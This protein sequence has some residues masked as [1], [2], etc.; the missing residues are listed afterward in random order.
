V[1]RLGDPPPIQR[2]RRKLLAEAHGEVLEIGVGSGVNFAHYDPANVSKL[3]ALEPNPEMVRLAESRRQRTRLDVEFLGLPGERIPLADSSVDTV[4]STFTLCT[5]AG[6]EE[7]IRG[8]KRVLK[9]GGRLIFFEIGASSDPRIRRWQRRWEP[10][11]RRL[12]EGLHLTRDIPGLLQQAG[13]SMATVE[14]GCMASFPKSWSHCCWGV[15]VA[16][17]QVP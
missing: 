4:V 5:I 16:R 14:T 6:V 8:V 1:Q 17:T 15:A 13:F 12:F 10:L 2:L 9:P 3:Y 7:A 11:H